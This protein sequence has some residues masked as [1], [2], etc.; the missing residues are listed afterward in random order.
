MAEVCGECPKREK[1]WCAVR[2]ECVPPMRPACAW[3]KRFRSRRGAERQSSQR[4]IVGAGALPQ[5]PVHENHELFSGAER[6]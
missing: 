4:E 2:G 3:R 5:T 1:G 6:K